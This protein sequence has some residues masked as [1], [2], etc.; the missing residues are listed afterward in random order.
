M[1][2]NQNY[3]LKIKYLFKKIFY[4]FIFK[5]NKGVSKEVLFL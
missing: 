3:I 1:N 5:S 2:N 4:S